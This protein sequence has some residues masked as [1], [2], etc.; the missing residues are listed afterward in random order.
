MLGGILVFVVIYDILQWGE[1]PLH[2]ASWDDNDKI[3]QVLIQSGADV[4]IVNI[5]SYYHACTN[6]ILIPCSNGIAKNLVFM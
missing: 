5:V 2:L 4:N 6:G 3:V 1:T